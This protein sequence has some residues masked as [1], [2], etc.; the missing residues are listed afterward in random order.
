MVQQPS[1]MNILI[2][3]T[4][5]ECPAIDDVCP[6][7]PGQKEAKGKCD[8]HGKCDQNTEMHLHSQNHLS[9]THVLEESVCDKCSILV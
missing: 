6:P 3:C 8:I 9:I 1:V 5:E 7:S 4:D 2:H